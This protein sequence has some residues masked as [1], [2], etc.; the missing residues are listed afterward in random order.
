MVERLSEKI[1]SVDTQG[2]TW[3]G[4]CGHLVRDGEVSERQ[5]NIPRRTLRMAF[6]ERVAG[7]GGVRLPERRP[8]A[9]HWSLSL[10]S[11]TSPP[12]NPTLPPL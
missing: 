7:M 2:K 8:G 5:L 6:R 1:K 4:G 12:L 11:G 9:P 10:L 3:G